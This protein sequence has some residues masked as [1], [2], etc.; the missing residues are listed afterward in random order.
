MSS[1][2]QSDFDV[3]D[4]QNS[5]DCPPLL[6]ED[7]NHGA[8]DLDVIKRDRFELLSAYLDGEVSPSEHRLV[9]TWLTSDPETQCLY[10]R[11]LYLRQGFQALP[12]PSVS[13][14]TP[15]AVTEQVY[16]RLNQGVQRT[17]MASFAAIALAV[18]G[19]FSGTL[20]HRLLGT[21][22]LQ[23]GTPSMGET[24]MDTTAL[25]VGA[26]GIEAPMP[27]VTVAAEPR[28]ETL[29]EQMYNQPKPTGVESEL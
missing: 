14:Q 5:A 23:V 7:L 13:R 26:K 1:H 16:N 19:V 6:K 17:C 3:S 18:F 20:S 12:Q 10:R 4:R 29:V 27:S 11:L 2:H 8:C 9:S 25:E 15:E 28:M 21:E 22:T 24:A